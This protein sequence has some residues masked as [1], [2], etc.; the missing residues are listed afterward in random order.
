MHAPCHVSRR[1]GVRNDHIFG[2]TEVILPVYCHTYGAA[3]HVG[4]L[5]FRG[6]KPILGGAK[7]QLINSILNV[8]RNSYRRLV[9]HLTDSYVLSN[10]NKFDFKF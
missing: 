8:T 1:Q 2:I 9:F 4:D 6:C 10:K 7:V 5:N 3:R